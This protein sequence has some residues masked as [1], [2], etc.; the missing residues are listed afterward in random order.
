MRL[1]HLLEEGKLLM[2]HHQRRIN[3]LKAKKGA[4]KRH[5]DYI[6]M[7]DKLISVAELKDMTEDEWGIHLYE[8]QWFSR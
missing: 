3:L 2:S 8:N 4:S 7:I 1:Y 5:S 6:D